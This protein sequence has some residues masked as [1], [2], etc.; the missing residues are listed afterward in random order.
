MFSQIL[1]SSLALLTSLSLI[2]SAQACTGHK[3][4]RDASMSTNDPSSSAFN[5]G[6]DDPAPLATHGFTLNHFGL[7][8]NGME[9]MKYFY[10]EVL[11]MRLIFSY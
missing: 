5:L 2:S 3:F 8:V 7:L 6:N 9:A 4:S 10:G 11:G 1:S